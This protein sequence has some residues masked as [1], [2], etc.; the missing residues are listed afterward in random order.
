MPPAYTAEPEP[1]NAM[2]V[3]EHAHPR[4][5]GH[6]GDGGEEYEALVDALGVRCTV[7]EEEIQLKKAEIVKKGAR[8]SIRRHHHGRLNRRSVCIKS[9][10]LCSP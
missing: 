2:Q 1:V 3:L 5:S 10:L 9:Y 7:L 4:E 8:E 6:H